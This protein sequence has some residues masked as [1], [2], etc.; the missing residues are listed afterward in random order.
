MK[1]ELDKEEKKVTE[2]QLERHK[3][4]VKELK[5]NLEYNDDLIK[6]QNFLREFDDKWRDYLR[7]RKDIE[8]K[9]ILDEMKKEIENSEEHIKM[10]LNQLKEGVEI[11]SITGVN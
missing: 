8:D 4:L 2:K 6:K 5:S 9:K 11:K 1:R 7:E 10:L 3:Q